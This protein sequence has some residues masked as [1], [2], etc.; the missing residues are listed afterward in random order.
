MWVVFEGEDDRAC[1]TQGFAHMLPSMLCVSDDLE[2]GGCEQPELPQ[3]QRAMEAALQM[4]V[5]ITFL[6]SPEEY[7]EDVCCQTGFICHSFPCSLTDPL[8]VP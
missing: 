2:R 1:L 3:A 6:L 7:Q 4:A 8:A 5:V